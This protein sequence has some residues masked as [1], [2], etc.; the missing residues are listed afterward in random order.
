MTL[1]TCSIAEVPSTYSFWAT[2]NTSPANVEF[3]QPI[4]PWE[5]QEYAIKSA[6]QFYTEL[7]R[8]W[9]HVLPQDAEKP[10][11]T[12]LQKVVTE[13]NE[14][15]KKALYKSKSFWERISTGE[16]LDEALENRTAIGR[17]VALFD[18][19]LEHPYSLPSIMKRLN[20]EILKKANEQAEILLLIK[21]SVFVQR[22][23]SEG[24][25]I[26]DAFKMSDPASGPMSVEDTQKILKHFYVV[27]S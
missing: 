23:D 26:G 19:Y 3:K 8:T 11:L 2:T 6:E 9:T 22:F 15:I 7:T 14:T 4:S 12:I 18:D 5:N 20:P 24:N 1:S 21:G 27:W 17:V 16:S 13:E 25:K 10:L